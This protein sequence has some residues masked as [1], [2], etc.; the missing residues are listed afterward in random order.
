[1]ITS[2]VQTM[3]ETFV[4]AKAQGIDPE[5][6]L[7]TVNS[8][9]FQSPFYSAYAGV[10][11]HPPEPPGATVA[12]GLKDT[13]LFLAAAAQSGIRSGLAEYLQAILEYA[14]DAGLGDGD[15][16]VGQYRTAE[17]KAYDAPVL[18]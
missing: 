6:F 15:W 17:R 10:M 16:A 4:Y 7:N 2:M 3:A 12:L 1:M 13:K 5:V 11:L 9:L 18:W 8:A 14:V